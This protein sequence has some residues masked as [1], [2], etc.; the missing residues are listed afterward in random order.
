MPAHT[1]RSAVSRA[2]AAIR[3][4]ISWLL[5]EAVL[6]AVFYLV[7]TPYALLRRAFGEKALLTRDEQSTYWRRASTAA[8]RASLRF[9]PYAYLGT[10]P[11][12]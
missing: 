5:T 7:F 8:Q 12:K 11:R 1:L 3:R 6:A 9:R 2:F 4:A 10:G